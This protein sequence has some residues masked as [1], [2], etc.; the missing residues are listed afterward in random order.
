VDPIVEV[1][2][3]RTGA[4]PLDEGART[5]TNET[6]TGF[7]TDRVVSFCFNDNTSAAI[8]IQLAADELA[9]TRHGITLKKIF[10]NYFT[11][12]QMRLDED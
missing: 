9:R 8:P 2:V 4:I 10:A 3:G 12:H 5:G 7:V 11:A 6:V 1:N